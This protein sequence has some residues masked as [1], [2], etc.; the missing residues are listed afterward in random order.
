MLSPARSANRADYRDNRAHGGRKGKRP[1]EG[2]TGQGESYVRRHV[3]ASSA[4]PIHTRRA[5]IGLA[6][7]T[8]LGLV[9]FLG[10]GAPSASAIDTCPNVV[11]R[12]GPSSKLPDCRAYELVTPA[13]TGGHPPTYESFLGDLPGMFATDTVTPAGDSVVYQT[14]GGG[15]SGFSATGKLDRYRARRTASGWVTEPISPGGD[16]M[17]EGGPGG[18]SSDHDYSVGSAVEPTAKLWPGFVGEIN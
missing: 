10:I 15:L 3:K 5:R 17:T 11:F 2:L 7:L 9:A 18:I 8:M 12:T 13:Y 6:G 16:Q 1:V 4:A 14:L